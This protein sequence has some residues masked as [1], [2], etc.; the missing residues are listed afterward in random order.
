MTS[1]VMETRNRFWT[2]HTRGSKFITVVIQKMLVSFVPVST[3]L[4]LSLSLSLLSLSP[5]PIYQTHYIIIRL[6]LDVFLKIPSLFSHLV[7]AVC[8]SFSYGHGSFAVTNTQFGRYTQGTRVVITCDSG[9]QATGNANDI[10][11]LNTGVWSP[12]PPKCSRELPW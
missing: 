10:T 12:H 3:S 9:Y 4:S 8:P 1:S 5:H 6:F 7:L 2:A 11:C